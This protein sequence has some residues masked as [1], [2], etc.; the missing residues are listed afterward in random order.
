M[1]LTQKM[2]EMLAQRMPRTAKFAKPLLRP[3][4]NALLTAKFN[5]KLR[6]PV[7]LRNP[8]AAD[9]HLTKIAETRTTFAIGSRAHGRHVL[10]LVVSDLR[11]DPRVRREARALAEAGYKV[12]VVCPTPFED[13][14]SPPKIAWGAGIEIK[15][16][17]VYCANHVGVR[18]GFVGGLFFDVIEREFA[19]WQFFA[20]HAHD[21]NTAYVALAFARLTGAHL[22]V[23]FHEWTSENV[24]WDN[25]NKTWE[26]FPADWKQELRDLEARVMKEASAVI[27]VSPSIV[28]AIA[29]EIGEGRH[30]TL[31]R[32]IPDV[33]SVSAHHYPPLREVL[34]IPRDRFIVLY[35]GGIGPTRCLEPVIQALA[36]APECVLVIRGPGMDLFGEG[37]RKLAE[38]EGISDRLYLLDAVPSE[39]VVAAAVGADAGIYTVSG[40]CRNYQLALPNKVYEYVVAGLPV[41]VSDY[42]E[43]RRFVSEVEV[44]LVFSPNNIVSIASAMNRLASDPHLCQKFREKTKKALASID[45]ERE[46]VKLV[47]LYQSLPRE[48]SERLIA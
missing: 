18:P 35:Q 32:N 34:N 28:N 3:I 42:P 20:V 12:I 21:L 17:S 9:L 14:A 2:L 43:V 13:T 19:G 7:P 6:V 39:D 8:E 47:E 23:D 16:V 41:L 48:P 11:S 10:M 30:A 38:S 4:V 5:Q 25:S 36:L 27:T 46:W 29:D 1:G 45:G 40:A 44:G 33:A 24:H 15:Y 26:Q 31:I 37:Y 22:V